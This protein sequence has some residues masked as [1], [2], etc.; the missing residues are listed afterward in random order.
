MSNACIEWY[1]KNCSREG[2]FLTTEKIIN[3]E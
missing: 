2:S 1:D 3:D